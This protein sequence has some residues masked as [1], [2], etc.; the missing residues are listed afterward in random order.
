MNLFLVE[1][2]FN[3]NKYI[4]LFTLNFVTSNKVLSIY[5]I[6]ENPKGFQKVFERF[7]PVAD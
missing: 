1:F 7:S 4:K 2:L 5:N 3:T 6:K